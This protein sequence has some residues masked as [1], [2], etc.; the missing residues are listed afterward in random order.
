MGG[1]MPGGGNK[2]LRSVETF[3]GVCG[4]KFEGEVKNGEMDGRGKFTMSNNNIYIGEFKD[5]QFHGK[6][7]LYFPQIGRYEG[8]WDRGKV[9]KGK[10]LF[11][12]GLVYDER[13]WEY[14]AERD[15]RFYMGGDEGE[16]EEGSP[17]GKGGDPNQKP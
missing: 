8:R 9:T 6:G 10:Y 11:E 17:G 16:E 14:C 12:D 7:T 15:R 5:G 1:P 4:S 3:I 2:P 13:R